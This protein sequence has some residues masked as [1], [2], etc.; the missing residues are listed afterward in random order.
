M[1]PRRALTS[2]RNSVEPVSE[3]AG[4]T[5]D[6]EEEARTVLGRVARGLGRPGEEPEPRRAP[7][8]IASGVVL[9]PERTETD[10]RPVSAAP[11][12]PGGITRCV[13]AASVGLGPRASARPPETAARGGPAPW[14]ASLATGAT[15]GAAGGA[16]AGT[17]A[18][19]ELGTDGL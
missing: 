10:A 19:G 6:A 1:T 13:G 17:L 12:R 16:W 7:R 4:D 18:V 5:A 9:A 11:P 14:A 2:E 8:V 3:S 15:G